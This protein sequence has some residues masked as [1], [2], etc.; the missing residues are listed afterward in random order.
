[1]KKYL[2]LS[3]ILFITFNGFSQIEGN[4]KAKLYFFEAKKLFNQNDYADALS[5]IAKTETTLGS[6]NGRILNLKIKTLY[7]M[8]KFIEAEKA[9]SLFSKSFENDVTEEMKN[10]TYAYFV[11]IEKAASAQKNKN[12]A[13]RIK[14]TAINE[15]YKHFHLKECTKCSGSGEI[16]KTISVK[17]RKCKGKGRLYFDYKWKNGEYANYACKSCN[18]TGYVKEVKSLTCST[19]NGDR[20]IYSYIGSFSFTDYEIKKIIRNQKGKIDKYNNR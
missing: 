1:M 3:I 17:H 7:N 14:Q 16:S 11:R 5:Y 19:C 9:L 18:E 15:A 4:T 13:S 2:F 20:F 6:T 12:E 10:D 8:G